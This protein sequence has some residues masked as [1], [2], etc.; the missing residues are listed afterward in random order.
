VW[1][2]SRTERAARFRELEKYIRGGIG[3]YLAFISDIRNYPEVKWCLKK[4]RL[5]CNSVV[6]VANGVFKLKTFIQSPLFHS[7]FIHKSYGTILFPYLTK[8]AELALPSFF[9]EKMRWLKSYYNRSSMKN[10]ELVSH[11]PW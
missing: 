7:P 1:Y 4:I 6:D 11:F 8:V 3:V 10:G 5:C 2:D 9:L